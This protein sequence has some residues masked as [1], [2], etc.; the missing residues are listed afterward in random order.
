MYLQMHEHVNIQMC[1][2]YHS[3][4]LAQFKVY[5]I[6]PPLKLSSNNNLFDRFK[7]DDLVFEALQRAVFCDI[8]ICWVSNPTV[9][10]EY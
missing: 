6:S 2:T 5:D 4:H 3:C 10:T 8:S 9:T 7:R 1:H